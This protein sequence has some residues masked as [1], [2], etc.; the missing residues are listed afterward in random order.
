M[1]V[2]FELH[3]IIFLQ[4]LFLLLILFSRLK[5]SVHSDE[6]SLSRLANCVSLMVC[7]A[8]PSF[9]LV[10]I[11]KKSDDLRFRMNDWYRLIRH[12]LGSHMPRLIGAATFTEVFSYCI[13][14]TSVRWEGRF[15]DHLLCACPYASIEQP[16]QQLCSC[17]VGYS[18]ER[19]F[20]LTFE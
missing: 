18:L 4:T 17:F 16:M 20:P 14:T 11:F 7:I 19:G 9:S 12:S 3:R 13:C 2:V 10:R 5:A 15:C 8:N 6:Q 1:E